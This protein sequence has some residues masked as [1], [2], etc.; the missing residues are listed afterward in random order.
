MGGG[1]IDSDAI[2]DITDTSY[3]LREDV[4][5]SF[6][7]TLTVNQDVILKMGNARKLYV[8]GALRILGSYTNPIYFTSYRDDTIGGDTNGDGGTTL[9]APGNW[10][11]IQFR[12]SS[13]DINSLIDYTIIRYGGHDGSTDYGAIH[14]ISASPTIKNAILTENQHSGIR[15]NTSTPTLICND[16]Y[17]NSSYGIYNSTTGIMV[18]AEN[19]WWGSYSGPYHPTTNPTGTG[20][21]V[22]DGVN[23]EPWE[24]QS[25][26]SPNSPP[27]TPSNPSPADGATDQSLDV[28]LSWTGGDPDGDTVTYDVYFEQDDATPDGLVSNDQSGPTYDP[29]TLNPNT[30][31]YWQIVATDEHGSS[32]RGQVWYFSTEDQQMSNPFIGDVLPDRGRNDLPNDI[33]IYGGEFQI[34]AY[35]QLGNISLTTTFIS[36]THLWSTVPAG[37]TPGVYDLT[38]IN[39]DNGQATLA[40]AYTVLDPEEPYDDLFSYW[41]DLWTVPNPPRADDTTQVGLVVHR[42]GGKNTLSN[43]VVRFYL[44]NP[45]TGGSKIGDGTI[46]LLSPRSSTSTTGVDWTPTDSVTYTL[47]AVIDPDNLIIESFEDNNVISRTI[48]V[49]PPNLDII[50]PHVDSFS[51]NDGAPRT[52]SRDVTLDTTASD[53]SPGTGVA[54]LFY[55]EYEYSQGAGLWVPSQTSGWLEYDSARINYPWQLLPSIGMKYLQAWAADNA[56]NISTYPYKDFINYNPAT[57]SVAQGQSQMY[58]YQL[59]AGQRFRVKVEPISGDPELYVWAPD[60]ATRPP[61]VSNLYI[62]TDEVDFTTPID[63]V[64]QVEVY[65]YT[66]ATYLLT[67][68][69]TS[70]GLVSITLPTAAELDESKVLPSQPILPVSSEPN[71]QFALPAPPFSQVEFEYPIYVPLIQR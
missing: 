60:H 34:G 22:T 56:G 61:W 20:N 52:S 32:T 13:N 62:G 21:Q 69:V 49:L 71:T 6:S 31:Y 25:C 28:N 37:L 12:D 68:E 38:V 47:Y 45:D 64:Y 54:S 67:V 46:P 29:S 41:Y 51:I 63:G 17:N 65:G 55:I 36:S 8:D 59:S 27:N 42:E 11:F 24:N 53:P 18:D 19:Q 10:D 5:I 39:P 33:N 15:T 48:T 16:I 43:I 7:S 2:W 26:L 9:P 23:Y 57:C 14:L 66:A 44:G 35:V 40:N 70:S 1:T 3:Y 58:R 50:A 30:H 4:T